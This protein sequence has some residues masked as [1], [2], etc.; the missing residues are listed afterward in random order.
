MK[1]G[2]FPDMPFNG[3]MTFPCE[4]S[5]RTTKSGPTLCKKPIEAIATLHDKELI[6]KDKNIIPGIKGN[7]IGGMSGEAFHIK[8]K[9]NPKNSDGFGFMIRNG[10]KEVGTEIRYDSNKKMLDCLGGQAKVEAKDGIIQF[11]ILV[12]R[13]SIEIFV[14]DGEIVFSSCFTPKEGDDD[15][16][17]WTQ[18]GELF[19]KEIEVYELKSAWKEK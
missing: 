8:A 12:D 17:L 15:L 9:L 6:K 16:T 7:L 1:G 14:N 3:Q 11:E 2:E 18:G 5:L 10:K 19:V 4:L 13:T